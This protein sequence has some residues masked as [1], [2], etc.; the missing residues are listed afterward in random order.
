MAKSNKERQA[1][2]AKR[3]LQQDPEQYRKKKNEAVKKYRVK[4]KAVGFSKREKEVKREYERNRKAAQR[5]KK[6]LAETGVAADDR[7]PNPT[8]ALF[9]SAQSFG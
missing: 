6:K 3:Q 9:S 4:W 7:T 2:F 5:L 8:P 1:K